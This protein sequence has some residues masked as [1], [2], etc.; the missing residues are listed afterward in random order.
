MEEYTYTISPDDSLRA[1]AMGRK[2]TLAHNET[3]EVLYL[4]E[5]DEAI[6]SMA[7]SET[8]YWLLMKTS[9]HVF[10]LC[11]ETKNLSKSEPVSSTSVKWN[12][13]GVSIVDEYNQLLWQAPWTFANPDLTDLPQNEDGLPKSDLPAT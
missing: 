2:F 3:D 7:F 12:E 11:L 4:G 1:F 5:L 10:V 8:R 6:E 13:D 9:A